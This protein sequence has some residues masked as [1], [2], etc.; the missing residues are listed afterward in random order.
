MPL[1]W[2]SRVRIAL[3]A[4]RG[5]AHLHNNK[6]EHG[7]IKS[8]NVLLN[9]EGNACVSDFALAPLM[10]SSVTMLMASGYKAP[11]LVDNKKVSLRTDMYSFGVLLLEILTGKSPAQSLQ[12]E[13]LDLARWV[14]S[15]V[16]EEWTA[17]VFDLELMHYK[18]NEQEMVSL[19]QIAMSC[20]SVAPQQRPKMRQVVRM[21]EGVLRGEQSPLRDCSNDE[22]SSPPSIY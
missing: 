1:D 10:P 19:L 18:D 12:D 22:A 8:S 17:E 5:I 7:N 6:I 9:R 2:S 21:I 13:G 15:V 3:G 4:A 14:Q 20:V 16:R 11:E